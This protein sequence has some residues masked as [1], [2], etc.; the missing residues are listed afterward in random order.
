M[1]GAVDLWREVP[2]V[3]V[4]ALLAGLRD[5]PGGTWWV[6]AMVASTL[7]PTFLHLCLAF[8][9]AVTWFRAGLWNALLA[10]FDPAQGVEVP[11]VAKL[12]FAAL[13]IAYLV[14]PVVLIAG[15]GWAVWA[16]GCGMPMSA[17]LS[18]MR[19][20]LACSRLDPVLVTQRCAIYGGAVVVEP[21]HVGQPS[22]QIRG[23]KL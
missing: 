15:A 2:L 14:I 22:A 18:V 3:G 12:G 16:H 9:S 8:V 4:G 19:I 5:D 17:G 13:F 1:I 6:V 11:L 21:L 10:R 7:L 20:G 23:R